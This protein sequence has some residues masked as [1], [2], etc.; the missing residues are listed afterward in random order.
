MT[1]EQLI[2]EG[3]AL[4]K[5]CV[6]LRPQGTGPIAA[7]WHEPDDDE[8]ESTGY[9]YWLTVDSSQVPAPPPP[10]LVTSTFSQTRKK[11][12]ADELKSRHPGPNDPARNFTLS[13]SQCCLQSMLSLPV[14]RMP[15]ANSSRNITGPGKNAITA[16]PPTRRSWM[17]M[18]RF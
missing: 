4:Q 8:I 10:F 12:G 15:L 14:A 5:P 18:R 2:S 11:A 17:D 1:A 13:A 9:R 6:V 16:I 7:I 3:R